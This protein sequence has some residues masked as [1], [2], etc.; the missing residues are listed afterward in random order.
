[1][2]E[3]KHTQEVGDIRNR[4][5]RL[6]KAMGELNLYLSYPTSAHPPQTPV[7]ASLSD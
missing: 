2:I 3:L 4:L 7:R 6:E 5:D 1:M